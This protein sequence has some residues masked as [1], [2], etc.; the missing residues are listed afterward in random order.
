MPLILI[1]DRNPHV[2]FTLADAFLTSGYQVLRDSRGAAGLTL[3]RIHTPQVVLV[4]WDLV[5]MAGLTFAQRLRV[6]PGVVQPA[7][8]LLG[9]DAAAC[10]S[11]VGHYGVFPTP[12]D[13]AAVLTQVA[14]VAPPESPLLLGAGMV[15]A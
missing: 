10:R 14:L 1:L 3:V 7:L 8:F 2:R 11:D 15:G 6:L 9:V 13:V 4:A 12:T 5:D